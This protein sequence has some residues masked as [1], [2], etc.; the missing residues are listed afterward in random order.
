M[1]FRIALGLLM[2][3]LLFLTNVRLITVTH[4]GAGSSVI[5]LTCKW[6]AITM[7]GITYLVGGWPG[8]VHDN[9]AWRNCR[10]FVNTGAYFN[11]EVGEYLLGM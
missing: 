7:L 10:L 8:S 9:R 11:F 5:L 2:A 3:L 1:A 4:I 6:S